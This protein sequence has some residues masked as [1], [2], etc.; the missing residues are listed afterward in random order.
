[1]I[2]CGQ[3]VG[4]GWDA[5]RNH[6]VEVGF[7]VRASFTILIFLGL[8]LTQERLE[9]P[10][11]LHVTMASRPPRAGLE[12]HS[13]TRQAASYSSAS[14]VPSWTVALFHVDAQT[15]PGKKTSSLSGN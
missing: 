9:D 14:Y 8:I 6:E 10:V 1:M 4:N 15:K 11:S 7:G 3:D 13:P 2:F 5:D 12:R